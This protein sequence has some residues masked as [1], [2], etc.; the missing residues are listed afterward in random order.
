MSLQRIDPVPD[1]SDYQAYF[2]G[3]FRLLHRGRPLEKAVWRRNKAKSIL[4]WFLLNSGHPYSSTQLIDLFWRDTP[5][6]LAFRNL[7]V[8]LHYLRHLLE[9]DLS[10]SQQ[11][12]YLRRDKNN[13]YYFE[14]DS[15]WWV[16][17][18]EV[19]GWYNHARR[20]EQEE[21]LHQAITYYQ[22]IINICASGFLPEDQYEDVF[23]SYHQHYDSVHL[24]ALEHITH[25][26]IR[27]YLFDEALITA[28]QMLHV[29]PYSEVAMCA[30]A[31]AYSHTG[32]VMKAVDRLDGYQKFLEEAMVEPGDEFVLL[33]KHLSRHHR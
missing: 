16:D 9:P 21:K 15:S 3:S 5:Q 8:T 24:F 29:D 13:V 22:R 6:E 18:Y 7:Y 14:G 33:K 32:N 25:L 17:I 11:S 19:D 23:S 12:R 26:Y 30:I 10:S 4:K 20:L 28:H 2:F 1:H 31:K 27:T